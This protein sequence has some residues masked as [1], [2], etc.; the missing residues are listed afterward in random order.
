MWGVLN[1][2]TA[3]DLALVLLAYTACSSTIVQEYDR[4]LTFPI[5]D[6]VYSNFSFHSLGKCD[7]VV[8]H[9]NVIP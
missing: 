2:Q 8:A 4:T 3:G 7:C 6:V 5:E 1:D 9:W